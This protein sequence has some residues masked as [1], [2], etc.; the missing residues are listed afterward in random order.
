MLLVIVVVTVVC[1][2]RNCNWKPGGAGG[3]GSGWVYLG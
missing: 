3:A 1:S 2:G